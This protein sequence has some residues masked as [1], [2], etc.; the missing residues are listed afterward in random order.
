MGKRKGNKN[1]TVTAE[2]TESAKIKTGVSTSLQFQRKIKELGGEISSSTT[3]GKFVEVLSTISGKE[4][5]NNCT[6]ETVLEIVNSGEPTPVVPKIELKG[7]DNIDPAGAQPSDNPGIAA[8]ADKYSVSY[9]G[10][11]ITIVD[12]G[13]EAYIGGNIDEPR[14]WVGF[15][16]DLNVKAQGEGYNIEDVDYT[17]AVRWGAEN[18]TTFLMWLTVEGGNREITFKNVEDETD[19][20]VVKINFTEED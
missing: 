9:V 6:N 2:A 11:T 18:D 16:V 10:D 1:A 17:D 3:P 4:I 15:L 5:T 7:A 14:K 19:T 8:N 13:I 12:G 20:V